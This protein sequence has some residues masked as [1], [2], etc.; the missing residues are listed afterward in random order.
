LSAYYSLKDNTTHLN[1]VRKRE[2]SAQD[3]VVVA[4][5]DAC[6]NAQIELLNSLNS[7]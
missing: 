2:I 1:E 5:A 6:I 3:E 7:P 4:A